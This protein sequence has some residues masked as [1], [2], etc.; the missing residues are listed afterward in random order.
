MGDRQLR[1]SL[2]NTVG[3]E[4]RELSGERRND[5]FQNFNYL[6]HK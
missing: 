2:I 4:N 1:K 5:G 3:D 6:I